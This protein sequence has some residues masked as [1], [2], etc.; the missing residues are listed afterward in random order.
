MSTI[1]VNAIQHTGGANVAMSLASN[2]SITFPN[3]AFFNSNVEISGRS[4]RLWI[5]ETG[6]SDNVE[7]FLKQYDNT[8]EG[9]KLT[10]ESGT[11]HSYINN[12]YS[13]G[14][15]HFQTSSTTRMVIDRNGLVT[16]PFMP[17]LRAL[18][19]GFS[20]QNLT[21]GTTY[22]IPFNSIESQVGSNYNNSTYRF[23][24]PV[25]GAYYVLASIEGNGIT[26]NYYNY[27][28]RVN[29]SGRIGTYQT[30]RN[31]GYEKIEPSG[32]VLCNAGDYIDTGFFVNQTNGYIELP[33]GD[34]RNQLIIYFLG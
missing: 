33:P 34:T 26:T 15:L 10:Y 3:T 2:G 30:G 18:S 14:N 17:Y 29:G 16:K 20:N 7:L 19:T 5:S 1:K 12:V 28:I 4:S 13:G 9:L 32:V 21:G 25:A 11:G 31:V 22:T 24:C 6:G 27:Y 8:T 23:T